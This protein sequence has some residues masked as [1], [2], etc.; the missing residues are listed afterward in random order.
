[1]SG[2]SQHTG[3]G[4]ERATVTV[5]DQASWRDLQQ[6]DDEG[7]FGAAWL[8]LTTAS[9]P[10]A[11]TA[12]LLLNDP[13][14][15]PQVSSVFPDGAG[16]STGSAEA[17][18]AAITGGRGAVQ[19]PGPGSVATSLAL[20]IMLDGTL[21][22]VAAVDV[23]LPPPGRDPRAAMRQLQWAAAWVRDRLR[24]REAVNSAEARTRLEAAV[25]LVAGTL[26]QPGADAATR[27]A[28]TELAAKLG[29][30]RVSIGFLRGGRCRVAS[31]SHSAAFGERMAL[32][33]AIEAAMDEAID[34]FALVLTPPPDDAVLVTS[35]HAAL[36]GMHAPATVLTVPLLAREIPVGAVTFE[37]PIAQPFTERAIALIEAV[38]AILGP[39]LADK[40]LADRWL[41]LR[42]A[43]SARAYLASL[44]GP[45]HLGR[46]LA[47]AG[48]ALLL[49]GA[50]SI[51][52]D[53]TVHA[54]ARVTGTVQRA[55][56][57]PFDGFIKEAPVRA[58]D[59]VKA[60]ALLVALDDRDLVLER[61]RWVTERQ[62][63]LAEYDQAM[64]AAKRA[65]V[66][67]LQSEIDQAN[68]RIHL[69]DEQLAHSQLVSPF[70]GLIVSGELSQ[71]I[72]APVRRGDVLL[73]VAPLDDYRVQLDIPEQQ[74]A[75]IAPGLHGTLVV[76]A[77]P[78]TQLP[79]VVERVTPVADA[80]DAQMTF[81][82]DAVLSKRAARLRP[83]MEGVAKI[84]A[85]RARLVWIWTRSL[86]NWFRLTVWSWMP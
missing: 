59:E 52:G 81:R 8:R 82:A 21:A 10:G 6:S 4:A 86:Q 61:L 19:P 84:D 42:A 41:V 54:H 12:A 72:G 64:S 48:A 23:T 71:S 65:D 35:A 45:A 85:G 44:I 66:V 76:N 13:A 75:D 78:N 60:G 80:K 57:A 9:I 30:E 77:L 51:K 40:R 36:A 46:K 34:Q 24:A 15:G 39:A 67:R 68:A 43:D 38:A 53:Y 26:D 27:A 17:I 47:L 18:K 11:F 29:C 1:M 14:G 70:D 79:L 56:S 32:T 69:V 63:H 74:I 5:L 31:I 7:A 50:F 28:A 3:E 33:R 55:I 83:G 25:D 20:P 37:R 58:G 16:L 62:V 49:I 22:A 2:A 73:E